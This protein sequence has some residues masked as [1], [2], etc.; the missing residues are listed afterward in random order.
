MEDLY[1]K[2]ALQTTTFSN[3][4]RKSRLTAQRHIQANKGAGIGAHLQLGDWTLSA[5][6]NTQGGGIGSIYGG[7]AYDDGKYGFS[8]YHNWYQQGGKQ[9]TGIIGGRAGD[10]SFRWENDVKYL[11]GDGHDRFRSNAT[12]IGYKDFVV[13]TNVYTTDPVSSTD[14]YIDKDNNGSRI[15]N[16]KFGTYK[17]GEQLSSPL[18]VGMRGK[19][20]ITRIG[21]NLP[22]FGDFQNG[23]HHLKLPGIVWGIDAIRSPN[24][25]L[26]NYSNPYYQSGRYKPYSLY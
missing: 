26:G 7:F 10:W 16:N 11:A 2:G 8:Y 4:F 9:Q 24:F 13:G 3:G 14:E 12:E 17:L 21:Y 1:L 25:R 19:H 20:G 15:F 22:G 23:F 5:G 6:L 18:Y